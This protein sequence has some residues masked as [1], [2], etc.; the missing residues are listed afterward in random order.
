MAYQLNTG[1]AKAAYIWYRCRNNAKT[2]TAL[3]WL[4]RKPPSLSG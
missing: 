3:I 2:V 1:A 4:W